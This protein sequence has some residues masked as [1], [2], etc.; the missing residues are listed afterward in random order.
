MIDVKEKAKEIILTIF[1]LMFILAASISIV[2]DYKKDKLINELKEA[3]E[4]YDS[5]ELKT[6][7]YTDMETCVLYLQNNKG[8]SI[9]LDKNSKVMIDQ[10]CVLSKEGVEE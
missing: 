9:M 3:L 2:I 1:I 10:E 5:D 8:V 4:Q 6:V 7:Y